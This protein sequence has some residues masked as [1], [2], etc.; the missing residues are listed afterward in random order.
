MSAMSMGRT[1]VQDLK[2]GKRF[3]QTF[4]EGGHKMVNHQSRC[5]ASSVLREMQSKT[6]KGRH[7]AAAPNRQA[8]VQ[9]GVCRASR[10]PPRC[11]R[12]GSN[13]K[14]TLEKGL[15][16]HKAKHT[17]PATQP[18]NSRLP[19]RSNKSTEACSQ[20]LSSQWAQTDWLKRPPVGEQNNKLEHHTVELQ[21]SSAVFPQSPCV[22]SLVPSVALLGDGGT[23]KKCEVFVRGDMP[24][25]ATV[26][27]W[28]LPL[29]L[30]ASW[31]QGE[32]SALWCVP[33]MLCFLSAVPKATEPAHHG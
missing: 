16:I 1:C 23:S 7:P 5:S 27:S 8:V 26:G 17:S 9:S 14:T 4:H 11:W 3:E 18:L 33:T 13:G 2:L 29:P 32:P 6:T 25:K 15:V 20:R 10:A 30:F 22:R 19:Q 21:V 24:L 12:E 31:P 28:S